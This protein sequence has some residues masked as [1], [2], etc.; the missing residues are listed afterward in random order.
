MKK[1]LFCMICLVFSL[2]VYSQQGDV[3]DFSGKF[4]DVLPAI[5]GYQEL[6]MLGS[7]D[8]YTI[9]NDKVS[10]SLVTISNGGH[11]SYAT[12]GELHDKVAGKKLQLTHSPLFQ[13]YL[14]T[15]DSD[16]QVEI[17]PSSSGYVN[18]E[19]ADVSVNGDA[20]KLELNITGLPSES[21]N[22]V[23]DL[24]LVFEV[25]GEAVRFNM[26]GEQTAGEG[27][28]MSVKAPMVTVEK[29]A[30][31]RADERLAIPYR[32][33]TLVMDPIANA[34]LGDGN[35]VDFCDQITSKIAYPAAMFSQFSAYY[36][37]RGRQ[38]IYMAA[39]DENGHY[40]RINASGIDGKRLMLYQR[41]Y[42]R[43][44]S[45]EAAPAAE[46]LRT[47]SMRNGL[48]YDVVFRPF[49]GD[50]IDAAD[51]YAAWLETDQP[52]FYKDTE[53]SKRDALGDPWVRMALSLALTDFGM[54]TESLPTDF[55]T[56]G[57]M[58]KR[59]LQEM[60]FLRDGEEEMRIALQHL[61]LWTSPYTENSSKSA[62]LDN[63][64]HAPRIGVDD[65]FGALSTAS[66]Y[67]TH[68]INRDAGTWILS[69]AGMSGF[70]EDEFRK[71][72]AL[73]RADGSYNYR[74]GYKRP[75]S[76]QGLSYM[77]CYGSDWMTGL[78]KESTYT[79]LSRT[80]HATDEGRQI[81]DQIS[82]SGQAGASKPCYANLTGDTEH[83]AH[84][85]VAGYSSVVGYV[86]FLTH[87]RDEIRTDP[88][89]NNPWFSFAS[90]RR[91]ELLLGLN[92]RG[93][94]SAPPVAYTTY[95]FPRGW[96][97]IPMFERL[98]HNHVTSRG[99]LK[100]GGFTKDFTL[101]GNMRDALV[102]SRYRAAYHAIVLG[103]VVGH[104]VS[105]SDTEELYTSSS[106]DSDI[107]PVYSGTLFDTWLNAEAKTLHT[108]IRDLASTRHNYIEYLGMG[109]WL[110]P[111]EIIAPPLDLTFKQHYS[112]N[113]LAEIPPADG[114]TLGI[115]AVSAGAY[116]H[117]I[118]AGRV[119]IVLANPDT[120]EVTAASITI[121]GNN[122]ELP[123][124]NYNVVDVN[125]EGEKT[126]MST[127]AS[128]GHFVISDFTLKAGEV[129]IFEVNRQ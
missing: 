110:R 76:F 13:I 113:W 84:Q 11:I 126:V 34:K 20:E 64:A 105:L 39:N 69:K 31:E 70:S 66:P 123:V 85:H 22:E 106:H 57:S 74:K 67:N 103:H 98:Y 30:N 128:D 129:H 41:H 63:V 21:G 75:A 25:T 9:E 52:L 81:I 88:T 71:K 5:E 93:H 104:H 50:W 107:D 117:A 99:A 109:R 78:Q 97:R 37:S 102:Y 59:L 43:S 127:L 3:I 112:G 58:G 26:E 1:L 45:V 49:T 36:D 42:N 38:G 120:K 48:G 122:L 101:Y 56:D 72:G 108:F 28:I 73:L 79:L 23:L 2:A 116:T 35:R 111:P 4:S 32:Q 12:L 62:A 92:P 91:H 124:G 119:V 53:L 47:F 27:F 19:K 40:K 60:D 115:G 96:T 29:I 10:L 89:L 7:L 24:S 100:L 33:G 17:G 55:S 121:D 118:D 95:E 14:F 51:I 15:G 83:S 94:S 61:T 90:E 87:L 44:Q 16:K 125:R 86:D 77:S 80:G 6:E 82:F 114:A 68:T 8:Q 54:G 65:Y 46:E 18:L